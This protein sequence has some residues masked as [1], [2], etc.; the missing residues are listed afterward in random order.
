MNSVEQRVRQK[1]AQEENDFTT[2]L[3]MVALAEILYKIFQV[4]ELVCGNHYIMDELCS[5]L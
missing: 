2:N 1:A 5:T 3:K 4:D